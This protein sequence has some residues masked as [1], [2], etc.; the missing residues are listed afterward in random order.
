[1]VAQFASFLDPLIIM[2]AVPMG[3]IELSGRCG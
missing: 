3:L 2:F 1:M